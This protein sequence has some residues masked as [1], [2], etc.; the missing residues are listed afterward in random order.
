LD[1]GYIGFWLTAAVAVAVAVAVGDAESVGATMGVGS[2]GGRSSTVGRT[3]DDPSAAVVLRERP[4]RYTRMPAADAR[5]SA[6]SIPSIVSR[7]RRFR[8]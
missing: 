8:F 7:A 1:A 4:K 3:V 6:V 5:K 2:K